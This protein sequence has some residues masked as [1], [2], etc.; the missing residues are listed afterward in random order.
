ML[1][2][3]CLSCKLSCR[4]YWVFRI[5]RIGI[6]DPQ[7]EIAILEWINGRIWCLYKGSWYTTEL[8]HLG[9]F[10]ESHENEIWVLITKKFR[11]SC[12][13]D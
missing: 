8:Y 1:P 10:C 11:F 3:R 4:Q 2:V 7:A 13:E 12:V 6:D 9:D 5:S